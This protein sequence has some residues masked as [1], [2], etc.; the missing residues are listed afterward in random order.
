MSG[1]D[2]VV[3][4]GVNTDYFVKGERLPE[5]FLPRVPVESVDATGAGDAFAGAL[6]A[7]L[8]EK[9]LG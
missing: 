3:V 1:H 5:R 9:R 7:A 4:G 6:A 2:V 8:A